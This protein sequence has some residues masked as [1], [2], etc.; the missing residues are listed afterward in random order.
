MNDYKIIN[1]SAVIPYVKFTFY[2]MVKIIQV[3]IS[4]KL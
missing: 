2:E 1:I 3:Y 4:E